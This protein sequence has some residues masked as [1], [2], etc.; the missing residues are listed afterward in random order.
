[1]MFIVLLSVLD[2]I[3]AKSN[4]RRK[5]E[6]QIVF[7]PVTSNEGSMRG[8][9]AVLHLK[10]TKEPRHDDRSD[11]GGCES[12]TEIDEGGQVDEDWEDKQQRGA[13]PE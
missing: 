2:A 1:M 13:N 11:I 10:F 4:C 5:I 3:L 6:V 7:F 12:E 9:M 8:V